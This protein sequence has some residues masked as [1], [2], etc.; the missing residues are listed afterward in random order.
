MHNALLLSSENQL[1]REEN[2]RQKKKT[3]GQ[4]R[5]AI[6]GT[7]TV[8]QGQELASQPKNQKN[9]SLADSPNDGPNGSVSGD[10][11]TGLVKKKRAPGKCSKCG[12]L[13]HTARTCIIA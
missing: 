12:S 6:G 5:I 9:K 4:K 11:A 3:K 1:L 10:T 13:G 8:A 2:T 7:L